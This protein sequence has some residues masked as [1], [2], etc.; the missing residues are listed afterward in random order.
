MRSSSSEFYCFIPS[1]GDSLKG[2]ITAAQG[3]RELLR[4]MIIWRSLTRNRLI[5]WRHSNIRI[6]LPEMPKSAKPRKKRP[7]STAKTVR[8]PPE[9]FRTMS[10][11]E[12]QRF[13]ESVRNAILRLFLGSFTEEDTALIFCVLSCG[14]LLADRF[15]ASDDLRS[16]CRHGVYVAAH[17]S[18]CIVEKK[19]YT[20]EDVSEVAEILQVAFEEISNID[21]ITLSQLTSHFIRH[22]RL[23]ISN[24]VYEEEVKAKNSAEAEK[25]QAGKT[26]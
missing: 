3:K 21:L 6:P 22:G 11:E 16:I 12:R 23:I 18:R 20:R 8:V 26:E 4:V 25:Q 2:E 17:I 19:P 14:V 9:A 13:N 24:I 15:E 1:E 10:E 7:H 5:E